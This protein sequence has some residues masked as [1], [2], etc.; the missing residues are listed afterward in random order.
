VSG[1][2]TGTNSSPVENGTH[3]LVAGGTDRR[4]RRA[5]KALLERLKTERAALV[6]AAAEKNQLRRQARRKIRAEL[7]KAP[8][9]VPAVASTTGLASSEVLWHLAAMRKYGEVVE[10]EKAGDY[11]TYRL[12]VSGKGSGAAE[13]HDTEEAGG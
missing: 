6:A 9:T 1:E 7:A 4:A 11:F 8:A 3:A 2:P 5:D 10:D 12:V 13:V